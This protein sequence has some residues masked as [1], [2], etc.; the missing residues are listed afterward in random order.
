MNDP[1]RIPRAIFEDVL[2]LLETEWIELIVDYS[3]DET[4]SDMAASYSVQK[5]GHLEGC[6]LASAGCRLIISSPE[7]QS[8]RSGDASILDL[9][10][11]RYAKRRLRNRVFLQHWDGLLARSGWNFPDI[12]TKRAQ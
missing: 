11:P 2:P 9:P 6:N 3:V 10:L 12:T 1:A 8:S 5:D 4:Q 7:G